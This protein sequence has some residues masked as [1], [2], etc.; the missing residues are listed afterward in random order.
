M[1]QEQEIFEELGTL[2]ISPGYVHALAHF[3]FRDNV[4]RFGSELTARDMAPLRSEGRLIKTEISTMIGLLVREPVKIDLPD[5][6][7][8]DHYIDRTE[9]LLKELHQSMTA[10]WPRGP[11]SEKLASEK[12]DF[13]A[14]GEALREPIFY[15]GVSAYDFQYRDLAPLKYANDDD[16]L[17]ANKGFRIG[18]AR[19]V[20]EA[21]FDLINEKLVRTRNSLR[22]LPV[23]QWTML[24]GFTFNAAEVAD[25][26][27][28]DIDLVRQVLAAFSLPAH[29]RNATFKTLHDFNA[30]NATPLLQTG[31]HEFILFQYYSLVEALYEAPFYWMGVDRSYRSMAFAH[32]GQFTESF[33]QKRLER[34][35]GGAHVHANVD[36][37]RKKGEK[38]GEIDV[39]VLFG[40]RVI[41]LQAKSKRLTLEARKGN[42]QQ[43]QDDFKRAVQEAYD[44]AYEC[45]KALTN[46]NC[47]LVDLH[48]NAIE[49]KIAIKEIYPVCIVSDHYPAL[50][51]Q[52]RQFL[53]YQVTDNIAPPIVADVFALDAITEMLE[54]PLHFLS[55]L[56]LRARFGD[57]LI[58]A[59]DSRSFHITLSAIYGSK[60]T[61]ISL[62]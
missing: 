9:C 29:D 4:V 3:C 37:I 16:W 2:C 45:A 23:K 32:R 56:S 27:K 57:R 19:V 60:A 7:V 26:S 47:K 46:S 35:F 54:S 21:V 13:A 11:D 15:G 48:G 12:A 36:I 34:V 40:D 18:A 51:F 1:R 39:L 58:A 17:I 20:T 50:G 59:Q 41:V 38:L 30:T 6:T 52:V 25:Q 31:Q 33:A 24:P 53:T 62:C 5:P 10:E 28:I 61:V 22:S 44:Q 49:M 8:V 55:Y 42:D 43:I 14:R